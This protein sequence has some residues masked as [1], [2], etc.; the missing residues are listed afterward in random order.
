MKKILKRFYRD[1]IY[2]YE[3]KIWEIMI[4]ILIQIYYSRIHRYNIICVK[5]LN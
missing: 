4:N 3:K 1:F 5:N 2:I